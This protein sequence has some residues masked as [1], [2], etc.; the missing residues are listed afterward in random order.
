MKW[1]WSGSS[2]RDTAGIQ[3]VRNQRKSP[4]S[5]IAA[6]ARAAKSS[7]SRGVFWAYALQAVSLAVSLAMLPFLTRTLGVDAYGLYAWLLNVTAYASEL[8]VFGATLWGAREITRRESAAER[9]RLVYALAVTRVALAGITIAI[10]LILFS[11]ATNDPDTLAVSVPF[12]LVI[13][14]SALSQTWYFIGT[15]EL[16]TPALIA[17]AIRVPFVILAYSLISGPEQLVAFV[18]LY[19][20]TLLLEGLIQS[21]MVLRRVGVPSESPLSEAVAF[22]KGAYPL[23]LSS[24]LTVLLSGVGVTVLGVIATASETGAFSALFRIPQ[25]ILLL[26]VPLM[27]AVYPLSCRRFKSGYYDGMRFVVR[28]SL[29]VLPVFGGALL[30]ICIFRDNVVSTVFGPE[31]AGYSY[32]IIGLSAWGFLTVVRN[33]LGEQILAAS[34]QPGRLSFSIIAATVITIGGSIILVAGYGALG[35][36]YAIIIGELS[37]LLVLVVFV[38]LK[39]RTESR[40]RHSKITAPVR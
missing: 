26:F 23:A 4:T 1:L 39:H 36:S 6:I 37:G 29:G 21:S 32:L 40:A 17:F 14:A 9:A 28:L 19:G 11:V 35:A 10:W 30:I 20:G 12:V 5:T 25:T 38:F 7:T 34:G 16:R 33:L 22:I 15:Q 31:Y 3:P 27:H 2:E 24:L 18:W 8:V 13:L